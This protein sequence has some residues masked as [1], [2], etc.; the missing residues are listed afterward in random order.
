HL[1][2][3]LFVF[4][5]FE[6]L[7]LVAG[8]MFPDAVLVHTSQGALEVVPRAGSWKEGLTDMETQLIVIRIEEPRRHIATGLMV[9]FHRHGIEYIETNQLDLVLMRTF[10]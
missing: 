1:Y 2:R 5:G 7:A 3:D 9:Y 4:T 10:F 8:E 6:W